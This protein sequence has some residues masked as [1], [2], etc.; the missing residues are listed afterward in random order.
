M[1]YLNKN[2]MNKYGFDTNKLNLTTL[3]TNYNIPP[4]NKVLSIN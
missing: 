3:N 2:V 1:N 4:K